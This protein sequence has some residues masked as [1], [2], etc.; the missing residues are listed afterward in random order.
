[1][2]ISNQRDLIQRFTESHP[3]IGNVRNV[4]MTDLQAYEN[5]VCQEKGTI[6][7]KE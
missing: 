2:R 6:S 1:M 7:Q 3:E 5:A 4:L